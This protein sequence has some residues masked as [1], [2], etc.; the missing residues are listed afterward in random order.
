[1]GGCLSL[2]L[3]LWFDLINV[4]THQPN[5]ILSVTAC[6]HQ[7]L[8]GLISEW[9][10]IL[11]QRNMACK[12]WCRMSFFPREMYTRWLLCGSKRQAPPAWFVGARWLSWKRLTLSCLFLKEKRALDK[13]SL[14]NRVCV[15]SLEVSGLFVNKLSNYTRHTHNKWLK[16]WNEWSWSWCYFNYVKTVIKICTDS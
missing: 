8:T 6:Y 15:A 13:L 7:W 9:R 12:S 2:T 14:F 11:I 3:S 16:K 4:F 1:M 5:T 10:Q